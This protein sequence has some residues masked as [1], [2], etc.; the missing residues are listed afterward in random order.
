MR[1]YRGLSQEQ[2]MRVVTVELIGRSIRFARKTGR[3]IRI[4]KTSRGEG[5]DVATLD[6][7]TP[8]GK[9]RLEKF[10]TPIKR[11]YTIS[12]LGGPEDA[13]SVNWRKLNLP[14]GRRWLL[15]FQLL[16]SLL[17]KGGAAKNRWL[18]WMGVQV[19]RGTEIMQV[20]WLDHFRPELI[21]IGDHTLIGAFSRMTV[22]A[23]EGDGR[24]RYGL[25]EIGSHC[26]LGAGTGMG[27]IRIGDN[28][29]TLPGSMLS[30]YLVRIRPG[31]V[32]GWSPP[33]VRLPEEEEAAT[34]DL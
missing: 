26:T 29:R 7:S 1:K 14:L 32:V 8:D 11:T 15:A 9:E 30:P 6:P 3:T 22:H 24:F 28:V 20:V 19:G 5:V 34:G 4:S 31:S 23:Y 10:L 21:S 25:I 18:R 2:I 27:P 17:L 33:D 12:G 16:I 13:N